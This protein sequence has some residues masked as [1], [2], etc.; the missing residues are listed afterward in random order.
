[1]MSKVRADLT[2]LVLDIAKLA[3]RKH[4]SCEDTYYNCPAYIED[5]DDKPGVCNCGAD[6]HNA[7]VEA[8]INALLRIL[9][10]YF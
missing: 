2:T 6:D 1:M 4:Y 5:C 10:I 8:K 7:K 9:E 3:Y